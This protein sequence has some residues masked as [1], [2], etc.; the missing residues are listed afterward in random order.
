MIVEG[1]MYFTSY[2]CLIF[3]S[4]NPDPGLVNR[5]IFYHA[6]VVKQTKTLEHL[7]TGWCM[8]HP[9]PK[10]RT[11]SGGLLKG[12]NN[13]DRASTKMTVNVPLQQVSYPL[14]L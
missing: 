10:I 1:C 9:R 6:L 4:R 3:K 7:N 8:T 11:L 14:L 12:L 13:K 2:Y 5:R